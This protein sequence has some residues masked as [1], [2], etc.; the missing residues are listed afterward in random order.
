MTPPASWSWVLPGLALL[1]LRMV[2][3]VDPPALLPGE[4]AGVGHPALGW[5]AVIDEG[6]KLNPE[7]MLDQYRAESRARRA[8]RLI[9]V[10]AIAE[11]RSEIEGDRDDP[12]ERRATQRNEE[13]LAEVRV[14]AAMKADEYE[15][16]LSLY[17]HFSLGQAPVTLQA[18]MRP[19]LAAAARQQEATAMSFLDVTSAAGVEFEHRQR[20]GEVILS[21]PEVY[22]GGL[23]LVDLDADG[24]L[25][26]FLPGG[27]PSEEGVPNRLYRNLGGF[28]FEDVTGPSGIADTGHSVGVSA[29]DLNGDGLAELYVSNLGADRLYLNEGEMRFSELPLPPDEGGPGALSGGSAFGDLSGDGLL[30]IYVAHHTIAAPARKSNQAEETYR[31]MSRRSLFSPHYHR[32]GGNQLFVNQGGGVLREQ[33]S[34]F[35]VF[36]SKGRGLGVAVFD[37]DGDGFTDLF[38]A[39]DAS[40]NAFFQGSKERVLMNRSAAS[41]MFDYRSGMGVAVSDFDGDGIFDLFYT[42]YRTE[43]NALLLNR[44]DEEGAFSEQTDAFGLRNGSL[45]VTGWGVAVIDFDLDGDEDMAIANGLPDPFGRTEILEETDPGRCVPEPQLLYERSG[46]RFEEVTGQSGDLADLVTSARGLAAGDIDRDGR[47]DLVFSANHGRAVVM[48]NTSERQGHWLVLRPRWRPENRLAIG[49]VVRLEAGGRTQQRVLLSGTGYLSQ[50]P[51]ELYFG[52]GGAEVVDRLQV[53]WPD[54]Q[55]T[56][57][58]GVAVD[59]VLQVEPPGNPPGQSPE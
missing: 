11:A 7:L 59:R 20:T 21:L 25:D 46:D 26:L 29:G 23:A 58:T 49:T 2:S 8:E 15:L 47:P 4:A 12:Y 50:A 51:F 32:P 5:E 48:R 56:E 38:V 34:E 22:G 36:D 1:G 57:M 30:D 33:A 53:E 55:V 9:T 27:A 44:L 13:R 3:H 16:A 28:R 14:L 43:Y 40:P 45:G 10:G 54:G 6:W 24:L 31:A 37:F 39:N 35:G 19:L 18:T 41:R 17:E 52:L 42:N